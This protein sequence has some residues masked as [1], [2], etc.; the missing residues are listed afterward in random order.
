MTAPLERPDH[1]TGGGH[2]HRPG[3]PHGHHHG[4]GAAR[5]AGRRR[6]AWTL[7]LVVAYTGAEAVGGWL[8]NSLALLADAGHMLSDAAALAL[9]LFAMRM[10]ARPARAQRTYGHKRVE[11]L[12][13]LANGAALVA[14]AAFLVVEALGRLADPPEVAAPGMIAVA[15]GGLL[16]NLAGLALLH[17]GRGES[18]NLRGAWL[19]V[20]TDAL[21]SVQAIA[22]GALIWAFG[23][24]WA[25]PVATLAIALLV[26][27]SA[28]A[29]LREAVGV[30]MEWAPRHIDVDRVRSTL[31]QVPGVVDVH[32][33]HVW[34]ITSGLEALS[35]HVVAAEDRPPPRL[36]DDI[37]ARLHR[38]FGIDH[39]TIQIE[40]AESGECRGC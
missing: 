30:L 32:D 2:L 10:A 29:L 7:A 36:L 26:V 5:A 27:W 15:A 11:I 22:A 21:G 9:A 37:R 34:T 12:A 16:V 18:L 23:W 28:W 31:H 33:L 1:P 4:P 14:I 19:H 17:G 20:A 8:T 13:A 25:D 3:E 24:H 39:V 38:R 40:S 6:L 35:A